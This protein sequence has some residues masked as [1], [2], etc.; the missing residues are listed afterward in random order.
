[1]PVIAKGNSRINAV[2]HH[3][4]GGISQFFKIFQIRSLGGL[5]LFSTCIPGSILISY[6]LII[7]V[8]GRVS[9][10]WW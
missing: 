1:M 6:L 3:R 5:R 9:G 4:R 2:V 7:I 10:G 8:G